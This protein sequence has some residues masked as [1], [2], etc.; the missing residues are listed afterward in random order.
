MMKKRIILQS[1]VISML[2]ALVVFFSGIATHYSVQ[3]H[4]IKEEMV[5][6]ANMFA[7]LVG[8]DIGSPAALDA[9]YI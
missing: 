6:D 7:D 5:S 4:R 2:T 3:D 8:D 1:F 9:P